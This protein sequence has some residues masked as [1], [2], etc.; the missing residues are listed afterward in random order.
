MADDDVTITDGYLA[1]FSR[2]KLGAFISA[3]N[4]SEYVKKVRAYGTGGTPL[5]VGS[6][7]GSFSAPGVLAA[8]IKDYDGSIAAVLGTVIDQLE[9]LVID[10]Q[11][12]DRYL[13]N[14]Q[15]E[16]LDYAQFMKLAERTL[17]PGTK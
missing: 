11:L 5:L 9:T 6:D 12:A 1:E 15:D 8:A 13:N 14:A 3:I 10:L 7:S 2:D 17:N 16:A 4:T